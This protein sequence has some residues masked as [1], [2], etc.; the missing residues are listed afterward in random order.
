MCFK[1]ILGIKIE[2]NSYDNRGFIFGFN[3][4]NGSK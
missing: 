3:N 2:K 4:G 1:L